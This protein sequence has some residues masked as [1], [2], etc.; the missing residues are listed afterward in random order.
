V[1]GVLYLVAPQVRSALERAVAEAQ[2]G[3]RIVV[4]ALDA[5]RSGSHS[6]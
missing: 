6:N 2:A 4:V 1:A 5:L 3:E